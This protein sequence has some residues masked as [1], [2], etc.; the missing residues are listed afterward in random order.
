M[1]IE[2]EGSLLT[3][4]L[5]ENKVIEI[6][7]VHLDKTEFEEVFDEAKGLGMLK[8]SSENWF[9]LKENDIVFYLEH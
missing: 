3:Q 8:N 6:A 2:Y 9:S 5:Q 7:F 1:R 4:V